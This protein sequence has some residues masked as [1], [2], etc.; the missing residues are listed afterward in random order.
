MKPQRQDAR[1]I[2]QVCL[3]S[4]KATITAWLHLSLPLGLGGPAATVAGRWHHYNMSTLAGR[5]SNDTTA[6]GAML[7]SA[8]HPRDESQL[9]PRLLQHHQPRVAIH[10][11]RTWRSSSWSPG[12]TSLSACLPLSPPYRDFLPVAPPPLYEITIFPLGGEIL[13]NRGRAT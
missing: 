12:E 10:G 8:R 2:S 6:G 9:A 11:L 1:A 5:L 7:T 3:G 4:P 13:E